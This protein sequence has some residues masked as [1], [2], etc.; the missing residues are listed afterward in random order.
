MEE[1]ELDDLAGGLSDEDRDEVSDTNV[2]VEGSEE[3]VGPIEEKPDD[4]VPAEESDADEGSTETREEL[5]CKKPE[6]STLN[7]GAS[8]SEYSERIEPNGSVDD[9][10]SPK[11]ELKLEE[12]REGFE[13]RDKEYKKLPTQQACA[14]AHAHHVGWFTQSPPQ[15]Q[16]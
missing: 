16:Y 5:R 13:S 11:E 3:S 8:V 1:M 10:K 2:L 6:A 15:S 12:E 4:C 7:E 14:S 9:N